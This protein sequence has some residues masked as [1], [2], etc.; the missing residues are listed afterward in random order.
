MW[1]LSAPNQSGVAPG[2]GGGVSSQHITFPAFRK[3]ESS[4]STFTAEQSVVGA[5]RFGFGEQR[6]AFSHLLLGLHLLLLYGVQR[7]I[8]SLEAL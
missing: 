4:S 5:S 6:G 8:T 2:P 1:Y 3:A 7:N